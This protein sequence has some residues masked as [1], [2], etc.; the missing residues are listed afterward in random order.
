MRAQVLDDAPLAGLNSLGVAA[1]ARR[2]VVLDDPSAL[3]EALA[4][5]A[6]FGER[7]VLGGGSN[8]LFAGDFDGAVLL[9][10]T[11]G[12]R[13]VPFAD[14]ARLIAAAGESWDE[15]V[16]WSL[17]QGYA[18]LE[19]LAMIPG[20]CGAA[21]IQNIGAYGL[22]LADRFD[23]LLAT[24]L[25]KGTTREFSLEDCRF[26]YRDSVFKQPGGDR[27]LIQELRLRVGGCPPVLE[28][29]DLRHRFPSDAPTPDAARIADAVRAIRRAKLP[30]PRLLGNAGSF[31]KNPVVDEL[32]AAELRRR[33]PAMPLFQAPDA[34]GQPRF[35]VPAGWLIERCGWKGCR[36]GD[37]GIHAEHALV[38]VNHGRASGAELLALARDIQASVASRYGIAL[39]P[40]PRIVGDGA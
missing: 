25:E 38:L 26:G 16:D 13:L 20:S 31:F 22:E 8:I 32:R 17:S 24:D 14:E 21:A 39:E 36:R 12:R 11:R 15:L 4:A 19:N 5:T 9:V 18:G 34:H 30:D 6:G 28:Y 7:L 37:A 29:A 40:E 10:R 27:W 23:S 1:R 35:K 3:A 2:L 33:E